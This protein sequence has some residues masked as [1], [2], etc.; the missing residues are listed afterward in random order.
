MVSRAVDR[1]EQ[2]VVNETVL[3]SQP[4]NSRKMLVLWLLHTGL[5]RQHAAKAVG[6][7][8]ATVQ[9]YVAAFRQGGLDGLRQWNLSCPVSEM[10][11]YRELILLLREATSHDH[12]R[13][14]RT[15]LSTDRVAPLP[16]QVRKFL[17]DLG[18]KFYRV[19]AIPVPPKKNLAEHVADQAA[20]L[21]TELKP[22]WPPPKPVKVTCSS[23]T[24]PISCSGPSCVT[25]G[26]YADLR[27][28][29]FGTS[30]VQCLGAWNAVT[31]TDRRDY[32]TVVNTETIS[33]LLRKIAALG[34]TERSRGVT[35]PAIHNP[36]SMPVSWYHA[37]LPSYSPPTYTYHHS[38][39][40][41]HPLPTTHHHHTHKP[42]PHTSSYRSGR[43]FP[44]AAASPRSRFAA[45]I[46]R[47]SVW[48]V[49]LPPTRSK[50]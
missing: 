43:Y 32:T 36:S 21:E 24:R 42:T 45:A 18:L 25:C 31:P 16:S 6:V 10:A 1:G 39:L 22:L 23:S 33:E 8:R 7:S 40:P 17:K 34:L 12:R 41:Y 4:P 30:A 35:T 38:P 15:H 2:R 26:R 29:G 50:A 5:T 47:T 14:V 13:G 48:I 37:F 9:R 28:C 46:S 27:A 11:A 44:C 20:F 19:C 3:S 49:S